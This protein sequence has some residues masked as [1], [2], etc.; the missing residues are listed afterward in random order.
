MK[1][2]LAVLAVL[3]VAVLF[4]LPFVRPWTGEP[5]D[6]QERQRPG[7]AQDRVPPM[8]PKGDE[9]PAPF[10]GKRAMGYLRDICAIGPRMSGTPGMKKQQELLKTHFEDLGLDVD[11]QKFEARQASQ[12]RAVEMTNLIV[13]FYPDFPRRVIL[14]C[15]YDTRPIADQEEDPR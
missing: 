13:S 7:F 15:H 6:G 9:K 2:L 12:A 10:D 11:F 8:L 14:C 4:V 1:R 3:V 5:V